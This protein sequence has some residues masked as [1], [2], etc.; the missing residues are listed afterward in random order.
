ML[1]SFWSA[2]EI[3]AAA[4]ILLGGAGGVVV[5][6]YRWARKPNDNQNA[7]LDKH[8]ELLDNDNRRLNA[9]EAWKAEK[10]DSERLIMKALYAM[11]QHSLDGNHTDKIKASMGELEEYLFNK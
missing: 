1:E 6:L 10:N 9:L 5:G 3:I 2:I 7:R 4:I 11:M 8:D